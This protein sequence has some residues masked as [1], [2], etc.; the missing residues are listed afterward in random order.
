MAVARQSPAERER[1]DDEC[2]RLLENAVYALE[3]RQRKISETNARLLYALVNAGC[4]INSIP[5][6]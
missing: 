5:D 4:A 1:R 3:W 2:T 6:G